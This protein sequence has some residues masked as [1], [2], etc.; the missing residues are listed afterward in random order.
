MLSGW[1][2]MVDPKSR[3]FMPLEEITLAEALKEAGYTTAHIGKWHLGHQE[4]WPEHQGFDVNI[5]GGHYPGPP[6]FFSP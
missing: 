2:K 4:Y 1:K 6:S 3:T 5:A